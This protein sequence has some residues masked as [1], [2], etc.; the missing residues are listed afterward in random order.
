MIKNG[1]F[2]I[3]PQKTDENFKQ[4]FARLAA[5]GVGRP[6][7]KDGFAD[8]PWTPDRLA[9]EISAVD[10]NTE[11]IELRSVQVWFQDN[12]NG[13]SD[14]N[15]RWLARIFGCG[16]PEAASQ[17]QAELKAAKERLSSQ[18]RERK[19]ERETSSD[20]G[21]DQEP[22]SITGAEQPDPLRSEARDNSD[23]QGLP[24]AK[25]LAERCERM[26]SGATSLNLQFGYWLVFCGL[27]LM[28]YVLGTLNVTYSPQEGL[29]KQVGFIWAPTLTVLPLIALPTFI[30]FVSKMNTYWRRVGRS[31]CVS[32]RVT[33][34]DPKSNAAWYAKVNDFSFSFWA[35]ALFCFLFVFGFQW[36]GIYLPAYL[37]GDN[38]GVQI[39]RYL[40]TLVR[41]DVIS[42]PEAM[43]LSAIGYMYTASYISI[44]MFGLLF[45]II[46]T[47][48]YEDI[49]TTSELESAAI[50]RTQLRNEGQKIVW[51]VFRVVVF[52]LWLATLVKLQITYLQSD[53]KDFVTWLRI[54]AAT[55]FGASVPPNGWLDNS[56][57]SHFTTFMMMVVTVT[58]FIVCVM[59]IRSIFG[60]LAL[61]DSDYPFNCD[62]RAITSMFLVIILL[63]VNLVLVGRFNG[64]SVMLAVSG[65]ATVFVLAGPKLRTF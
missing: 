17:W 31:K 3:A 25:T 32:D 42:I 11:G 30:F 36:A 7:D 28:N 62:K 55:A 49:C 65:L 20:K 16:D 57:I 40:V 23:E 51:A 39:D 10:G 34:I 12:D 1:R 8:G 24:I 54:D 5:E 43:V 37:S 2:H 22:T 45:S 59:K 41:P 44:F 52:A 26:L 50:D 48:D 60:R 27:G 47:L 13:I 29:D 18:R 64:F 61:Y 9:D 63:S 21:E 38:N 35:I 56:S 19:R 58:I 53:S 15:I 33:T 14:T 46:V 4:L 6:V